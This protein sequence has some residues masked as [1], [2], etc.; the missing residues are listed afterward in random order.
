MANFKLTKTTEKIFSNQVKVRNVKGTFRN[1]KF[2]SGLINIKRF[3]NVEK[4]KVKIQYGN[5]IDKFR[6]AE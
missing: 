3:I 6:I 4:V 5:I 2:Q 1:I